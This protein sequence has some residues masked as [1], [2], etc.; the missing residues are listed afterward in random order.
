MVR[1]VDGVPPG[2]WAGAYAVSLA[3][4]CSSGRSGRSRLTPDNLYAPDVAVEIFLM[5][6]SDHNGVRPA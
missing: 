4:A 2:R 6:R 3:S 1:L 5:H